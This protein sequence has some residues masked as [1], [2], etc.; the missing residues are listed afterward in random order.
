MTI[1]FDQDYSMTIDGKAAPAPASF[2]AYNP[3]TEEVIAR[4]PDAAAGQ[5]DE[6]VAA[7]RRAFPAWSARPVAE[8]QALVARIGD[9]IA[10]HS[11]AFMRLL[12]KEQG[13][14]RAGAEWEIGGSVIWCHEIAKQ[15]LPVEIVEQSEGR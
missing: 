8:R 6:D 4:V 1:E 10:A 13:K 9:A 3:A 2:E 12:T 14:P 7:A 11:E 5:L 15:S